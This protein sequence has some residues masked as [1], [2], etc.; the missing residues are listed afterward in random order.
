MTWRDVRALL[1]AR[2]TRR[3]MTEKSFVTRSEEPQVGNQS[4]QFFA[5][6]LCLLVLF[7]VHL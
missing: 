2:P 4:N 3:A 5:F 7:A 6:Y 1:L